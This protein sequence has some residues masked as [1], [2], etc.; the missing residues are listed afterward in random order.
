MCDKD[1]LTT[2]LNQIA[3]KA[4]SDLSNFFLSLI[5]YG[6]Y[7]RGDY[8]TESDINILILTTLEPE[9]NKTLS[10]YF[11]DFLLE[12]DLK[13]DVVTSVLFVDYLTYSEYKAVYPLFRT[14][15]AEGVAWNV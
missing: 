2:I 10:A 15:Q 9:Q 3:K 7:A 6:S 13:Y 8:D 4:K 5:L 11:L 1:T 14:I 12:I